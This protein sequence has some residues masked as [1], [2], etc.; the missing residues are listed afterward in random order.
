[1]HGLSSA[2]QALA[3]EG[4]KGFY[5]G[6]VAEAIVTAVQQH[7]GLMTLEDLRNHCST[8]EDPV[9]VEYKGNGSAQ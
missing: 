4:A 3:K 7:G 8:Y 1:M 6:H 5:E 9:S 2:L